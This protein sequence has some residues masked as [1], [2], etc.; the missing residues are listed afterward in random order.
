[1]ATVTSETLYDQLLARV[2]SDDALTG[3]AR[4]LV[5]AAC[6][7]P[8]AL[9]NAL[10]PTRKTPDGV[11]SA[12]APAVAAPAYLRAITVEGFR[13]IGKAAT[14][15]VSPGNGLTLV[16]GRNGSGK[17]SFA[18]AIELLLTGENARW[19][20]RT[21]VWKD[22]WRSLHHPTARI[23]ATFAR[24]GIAGET[25]VSTA[26]NDE[27]RA[28]GEATVEVKPAVAGGSSSAEMKSDLAPF[29]GSRLSVFAGHIVTA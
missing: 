22:G 17:S 14:L 18:E 29:A 3:E 6:Q 26:R 2:D 23:T 27:T 7:G 21:A 16:V 20:D 1:M 4:E 12:E 19:A 11:P 24:D 28:V 8:D 5:L 10:D 25:V 9:A 15:E 13:G